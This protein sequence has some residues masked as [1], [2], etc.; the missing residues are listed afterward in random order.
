V[1]S[2][3]NVCLRSS[4]VK[5][6]FFD[7]GNSRLAVVAQK[8]APFTFFAT[9]APIRM[10]AYLAAHLPFWDDAAARATAI[11]DIAG[12][13]NSYFQ[14][15]E[16]KTEA[17]ICVT[18]EIEQLQCEAHH[19]LYD[20]AG[21]RTASKNSA[22][23]AESGLLLRI[24]F[25][26]TH[27]GKEDSEIAPLAQWQKDTHK[28]MLQIMAESPPS[29]RDLP[30]LRGALSNLSR[31]HYMLLA[32]KSG[33]KWH[34]VAQIMSRADLQIAIAL[35]VEGA[36][37]SLLCLCNNRIISSTSQVKIRGR[38]NKLEGISRLQLK[39]LPRVAT[40]INTKNNLQ[41]LIGAKPAPETAVKRSALNVAGAVL[42][43]PVRSFRV[44]AITPFAQHVAKAK[45]VTQPASPAGTDFKRV[46]KVASL[47]TS[48]ELKT[49]TP[50]LTIS[51]VNR[52]AIHAQEASQSVSQTAS[53]AVQDLPSRQAV[54]SSWT[55]RPPSTSAPAQE[56]HA[57]ISGR[58][59]IIIEAPP[60]SVQILSTVAEPSP[61]A[62]D[63]NVER[64]DGLIAKDLHGRV[65]EIDTNIVIRVN[66]MQNLITSTV[67]ENF[68]PPVNSIDKYAGISLSAAP[69]I[70]E[71]MPEERLYQPSVA[72]LVSVAHM[73]AAMPH[74]LQP[75]AEFQVQGS[76]AQTPLVPHKTSSVRAEQLPPPVS[77][78]N[79]TP[80]ALPLVAI[81]TPI[82]A[83]IPAL[84]PD[85][86]SVPIPSPIGASQLPRD[87]TPLVPAQQIEP[88]AEYKYEVFSLKPA[89]NVVP[90]N[91]V[92][93]RENTIQDS[94]PVSAPVSEG[95]PELARLKRLKTARQYTQYGMC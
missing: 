89:E 19:F 17:V 81:S 31:L 39:A 26:D 64:N 57:Q 90:L 1:L 82:A 21:V 45:A 42:P 9:S 35:S 40:I 76:P 47:I 37:Q 91:T 18:N 88:Q 8:L 38:L 15:P 72:S 20:L 41:K 69:I 70:R 84:T 10:E 27:Q 30:P 92:K 77:L 32:K 63:S 67:Q 54:M 25:F 36:R 5:A 94:V 7:L 83:L 71:A 53:Q 14:Q 60:D 65:L 4:R 50:A 6:R 61:V 78:I 13:I 55:D 52:A 93:L 28:T 73:E 68:V 43:G 86:I 66:E 75:A 46:T 56:V 51:N 12:H 74:L 34:D 29:V 22:E 16:Q 80:V 44:S 49:I 59:E 48:K 23:K 95:D 62:A 85:P 24:S 11:Q 79:T 58:A 2:N 33:T 87:V 3:E